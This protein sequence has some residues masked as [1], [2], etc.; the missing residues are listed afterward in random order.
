MGLGIDFSRL[1]AQDVLDLAVA[2]EKEAKENYEQIATWME[3]RGN[4]DVAEFFKMMADLEQVHCDQLTTQRR[5][6]FGDR[7]PRHRESVAWEVETPDYDQIEMDMSIRAALQAALQAEVKAHDYYAGALEYATDP[8]V[9]ALFEELRL[10]EQSH[11]RM[12]QRQLA[13]LDGTEE[14]AS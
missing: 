1:E 13:R 2:A 4:A 8:G 11:Q 10:A 9:S 6:M 14:P 12:I 3:S 5:Q 7:P